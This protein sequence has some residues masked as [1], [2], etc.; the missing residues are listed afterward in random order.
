M[1]GPKGDLQDQTFIRVDHTMSNE[2]APYSQG[3]L[4][5]WLLDFR[6]VALWFK[7]MNLAFFAQ[8]VFS[9]ALSR[10]T[11]EMLIDLGENQAALACGTVGE[12]LSLPRS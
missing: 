10:D 1:G 4:R 11:K 3:I 12:S 8:A 2:E 6:V 5:K 7:V 9:T